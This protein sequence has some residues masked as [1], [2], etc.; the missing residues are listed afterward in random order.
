M[1]LVLFFFIAQLFNFSLWSSETQHKIVY[2]ISGPRALSTVFLRMMESRGDFIVYNEPTIPIYNSAFHRE[3]TKEWYREDAIT[4]FEGLKAH[5]FDSAEKSNVF[6]K[7]MSI[8]S[9]E[10]ILKDQGFMKNP[11]IYFLFLVRNPHHTA[12]SFYRKA[13]GIV[14]EMSELLGLKKLYEEYEKI[15]RINPNGVRIVF[16]ED[17]YEAPRS[18]MAA[19]CNYMDLPFL[20]SA[21]VWN[22]YDQE[23]DG[24][25]RWNE[26]KI[27]E[28]AYHWH[29]R[30][31]QS[32]QIEK[33]HSY[34]TDEFGIPT[35]S[36]IAELDDRSKMKEIYH[37][38][39]IYYRKFL[40]AEKDFLSLALQDEK[41]SADG[42]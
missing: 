41:A 22:S 36:E 4:T 21:F 40:H 12:I 7:D 11:D 28:H 10:Y 2:L 29:D 31:I 37:E 5:I 42:E 16:S 24:H 27:E 17:L 15:R 19:L 14:Q 32:V 3:K 6:I 8:S 34:E 38:N 35:F 25:D 30:A 20:E 1:R 18:T 39:L 33:P 13:N 23:F 26:P 9:H